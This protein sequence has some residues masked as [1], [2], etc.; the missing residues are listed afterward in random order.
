MFLLSV[1]CVRSDYDGS[2]HVV[3][4]SNQDGCPRSR[5]RGGS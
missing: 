4:F 3:G 2:S 1:A 5:R